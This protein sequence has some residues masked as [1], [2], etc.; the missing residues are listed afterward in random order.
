MKGSVSDMEKDQAIRQDK[1]ANM[2]ALAL[3]MPKERFLSE[4]KKEPFDLGDEKSKRLNEIANI[5]GV[6]IN[7]VVARISM[8]KPF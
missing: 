1:E 6:S 5:F 7:A 8:L 2:F 4:L 3:L